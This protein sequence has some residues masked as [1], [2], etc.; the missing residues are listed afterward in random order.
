[1]NLSLIVENLASIKNGITV[2]AGVSVK[3]MKVKLC[4]M[5]L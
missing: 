2:N 3:T 1:M 5:K 4:V